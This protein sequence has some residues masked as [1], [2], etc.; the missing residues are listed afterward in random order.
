MCF[1]CEFQILVQ[2][3]WYIL[4]NNGCWRGFK[5]SQNSNRTISDGHSNGYSHLHTKFRHTKLPTNIH[6]DIYMDVS[7]V[8]TSD[9]Y[10]ITRPGCE[11]DHKQFTKWKVHVTKRRWS[12]GDI[13]ESGCDKMPRNGWKSSTLEWTFALA[14]S[15]RKLKR[16][17]AYFQKYLFFAF[18][19]SFWWTGGLL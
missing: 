13:M 15:H 19:P 16:E 11:N 1:F 9:W 14:H 7:Q 17:A 4:Q 2:R 10:Y 18:L 5:I 12:G 3:L 6:T 8:P